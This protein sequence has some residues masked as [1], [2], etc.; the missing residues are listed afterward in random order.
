MTHTLHRFGTR[1][2]FRDDF[3]VTAMP[4]R[5]FNDGDCIPKQRAF[6]RAALAHSPINI[7]NSV[8]GAA[9][10]A[11]KDLRPTVHW[12]REDGADPE[13][14]ILEVDR[15]T[16]VSATF[17]DF[18]AVC[19]FVTELKEMDL[20]LSV[21]VSTTWTKAQECC[22]RCD[23][24]RHTTGCAATVHDVEVARYVQRV[25]FVLGHWGASCVMS[26]WLAGATIEAS[27]QGYQAS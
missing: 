27:E 21:N 14:V 19:A 18:D 26:G 11:S 12:R 8:K 7:G 3:I 16:T 6:L 1:E 15:P 23:L 24:T 25:R 4:A 2:D 9:H 10:R 22:G 20:G 13:Q 17:A 5:G